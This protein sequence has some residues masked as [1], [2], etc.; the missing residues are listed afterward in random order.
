MSPPP[1]SAK[2][3]PAGGTGPSTADLTPR[4]TQILEL[5]KAGKGNKEIAFELG[6]NIGTVKQ[7]VVALFKKLN[8]TNRTMAV[9]QTFQ[10]SPP[11]SA[12]TT[13][14]SALHSDDLQPSQPGAPSDTILEKRP[15]VVLSL[16]VSPPDQAPPSTTQDDPD[17]IP[18]TGNNEDEALRQAARHLHSS[19]AALAYDHDAV[20]LARRGNAADVI[21][22]VQKTREFDLLRALRTAESLASD[23]ASMA[24]DVAGYLRGGLTASLAIASM[25]RTGGWSG[26]AIASA[27]ISVARDLADSAPP[28]TLVLGRPALDLMA[29]FGIGTRVSS[30]IAQICPGNLDAPV[31]LKFNELHYLRSTE[32]ARPS[33][34]RGRIKELS[35]LFTAWDQSQKSP[36][37]T[38]V[39][40][41]VLGEAGMG[42]SHLC[43][44]FA[45][46]CRKGG[47]TIFFRRCEPS[48]GSGQNPFLTCDETGRDHDLE[49]ILAQLTEDGED[50]VDPISAERPR[51]FII[52]DVHWLSPEDQVR[53]VDAARTPHPDRLVVIAARRLPQGLIDHAGHDAAP[54]T[55]VRLGRLPPQE[56][57]AVVGDRLEGASSVKPVRK[58]TEGSTAGK[59]IAGRAQGVP[60]FAVELA[61]H[62]ALLPDD[63][64]NRVSPDGDGDNPDHTASALWAVAPPLSLLTIICA[65]LDNQ[66]IDRQLLHVVAHAS[67][68]LDMEALGK[69]LEESPTDLQAHIDQAIRTGVLIWRSDKSLAF[70]HPLVRVVVDFLGME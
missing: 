40:A 34:L 16:V 58:G 19:L 54:P 42:K 61:R 49:T 8:V 69:S 52:D 63:I 33:P 39:P 66:H 30:A 67:E 13:L 56:I 14:A 10:T 59:G 12:S 53:L 37:N 23:L 17:G 41:F 43:L 1:T 28:G 27:G 32:S 60:L 47:A 6:I 65:R 22:G 64:V 18:P 55:V 68:P 48:D 44:A 26:E 46:R 2:S 5:L 35:A 21:F 50:T 51:L 31:P 62:W 36:G 4:Q 29:A 45:E 24:P 70:S 38:A 9:A 3:P 11:L 7:H 20:F 25:H 57:E 15:C